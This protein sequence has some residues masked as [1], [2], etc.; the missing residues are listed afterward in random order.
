M[1]YLEVQDDG[2]LTEKSELA[3]ESEKVLVI[4]D[5]EEKKMFLWKGNNCPIR[6]KFIGSRA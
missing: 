3:L 6:K 4:V 2:E 5:E 1:R